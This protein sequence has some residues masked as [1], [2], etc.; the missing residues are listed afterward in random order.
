M[1]D[2]GVP[3]NIQFIKLLTAL[4]IAGGI[5]RARAISCRAD[6]RTGVG[7][8]AGSTGSSVVDRVDVPR[9]QS[10]DA[11]Q[12]PTGERELRPHRPVLAI[13]GRP[14]TGIHKAVSM[15]ESRLSAV[16][17]VRILKAVT[18]VGIQTENVGRGIIRNRLA[19]RVV[20]HEL[21]PVC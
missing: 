1:A 13:T 9:L 20:A 5:L 19:P 2:V 3:L 16:I 7:C 4:K 10:P 18:A 11:A 6:R 12:P 21:K 8:R 17:Q 15:R 14:D